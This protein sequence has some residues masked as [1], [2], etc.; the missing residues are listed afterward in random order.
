MQLKVH[1]ITN[2]NDYYM[3]SNEIGFLFC[4]VLVV[5]TFITRSPLITLRRY[6]AIRFGIR[7]IK[8]Y[9]FHG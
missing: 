8:L 7:N 3:C 9:D 6:Y 5:G 1:N 4:N 2:K